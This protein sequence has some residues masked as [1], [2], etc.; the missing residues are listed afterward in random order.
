MEVCSHLP[1]STRNPTKIPRRATVE[2][3]RAGRGGSH[4]C[5][6]YILHTSAI[7]L[8]RLEATLN[9]PDHSGGHR[10]TQEV[11]PMTRHEH[12]RLHEVVQGLL[13]TT[14]LTGLVRQAS[15]LFPIMVS[16]TV[17]AE[18]LVNFC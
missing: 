8:M 11:L 12:W 15:E 9:F 13:M 2:L 4:L 18:R 7:D 3:M 6:H 16:A 1:P 5:M 17:L 10:I 14:V